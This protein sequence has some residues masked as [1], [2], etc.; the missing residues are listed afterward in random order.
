M[1]NVVEI[2][3]RG[4]DEATRVFEQVGSSATRSMEQAEQSVNAV[5]DSINSVSDLDVD[6]GNTEQAMDSASSSVREV[7]TA[8]QETEQTGISFSERVSRAFETVA[9]KWKEITVVAGTAGTAME[10]FARSQG[11]VNATFDRVAI[12]TGM[13]SEELR[14]LANEMADTTTSSAQQAEAFEMLVQRG[15]D[16]EE[17]FR[18]IIPHISN[19][20]TA[21]GQDL[22][23][24]IE[25]TER[26]LAPFG[27][28]V[29]DVGD[30]ID[31]LGR[32][33]LQTDIPMQSL[34]RNLNM[35]PEELQKLEWG[36]D[37]VAAGLEIFRDK[38]FTGREAVREFRRAVADSEGDMNA[39][40]EIVGLTSD[41]WEEYQKKAEPVPGLTEEMAAANENNMTVIQKVHENVANL[42]VE[43]GAFADL[44]SMLAPILISMGPILKGVTMATQ[45]FNFVL[46]MN[47]IGL[48]ITAIVALIAIIALLW[49]NWDT[50]SQWLSESWQWI[51]DVATELFGGLGE[52]FS[53]FWEWLKNLIIETWNAIKEFFSMIWENI[54]EIF[55]TVVTSIGE[56]LSEAWNSIKETVSNVWNGIKDFFGTIWDE[57]V[58]VI[59]TY[60]ENAKNN[61]TTIFNAISTI[62]TTIWETIKNVSTTVWN[63]IV[64]VVTGIIN[65]FRNGI[66]NVFNTIRNII[67]T[68]WNT[69]K[70]ISTSVWNGIINTI[71]GIINRLRSTISTVFNGIRTAITN[72]WNGIKNTTRRI[73]DG[74]VTVVKAPI[75]TIIGF[76][77][78]MINALNSISISIPKIPD[79]VPGIGGRGGGTIGFNIPNVPSLATG[80]VVSEPTLAIVGD[81]GRGNPEIVAPQKMI[82]QIVGE[83]IKK[84]L[85][86]TVRHYRPATN[87]APQPL[88][89][90]LRIGRSQFVTLVEDITREQKRIEEQM[91]EYR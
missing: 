41:E 81:A 84:A 27:Q 7:D 48:V 74:I 36:L 86:E 60:I 24:T 71:S 40:L 3:I 61:I 39:F 89:I 80:G 50:V 31:Q 29:E 19:L 33:M 5:D 42:M 90:F 45:A 65:G 10:G 11:E 18:E 8:I 2:A 26:L 68:I 34:E 38:G 1:A 77:N 23:P 44:A 35:I 57:I 16:T 67:S 66:Q 59:T 82:A 51:K 62:I 63:A 9:D 47:P 13:T 14:N 55:I 54:K 17:Q 64:S 85:Q 21:V 79:W 30:N 49:K 58:S 72:V 73:W 83:E 87:E 91:E 15:I 52:Y 75:N 32:L 88:Q 70:N 46:K 28:G 6:T 12:S 53:Q 69:I 22:Q 78:G 20:G 56:W 25:Q 4:I 37:D 43:Y 76:I